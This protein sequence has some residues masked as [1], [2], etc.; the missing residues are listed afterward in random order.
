MPLNKRDI[1]QK[2]VECREKISLH[3]R[4]FYKQKSE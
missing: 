1:E 4:F 2:K 3:V